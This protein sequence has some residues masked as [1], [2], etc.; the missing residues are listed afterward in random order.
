MCGFAGILGLSGALI[1]AAPLRAMTEVQR[2]RG[3]D[4]QAFAWV[5]AD[6]RIV[7]SEAAPEA[8]QPFPCRFA[9]GFNRLSIR[10]LSAAGRQ[11]MTNASGTVV[12][13]F[14]G[15]IYNADEHRRRLA[16]KGV[17][18]RGS[19]DTEVILALY[20]ERGLDGMLASL[21]GM[22]ALVLVDVARG[23][24]YLIRDRLGIKPLYYV[25]RGEALLVASE[26]KA[27]LSVPGFVPQADIEGLHETLLFRFVS[28]ERQL[29]SG[30]R[31]VPPGSVLQIS[32]SGVCMSE[33]WR[34]PVEMSPGPW[35]RGEVLEAVEQRLRASV[36]AQLISDVPVGCQLSGGVDSS[37]ISVLS[38]EHYGPRLEGFSIVPDDRELSEDAWIDAASRTVGLTTH[39]FPLDAEA[40]WDRLERAAWHMDE[41]IAHP[42]SVG[43]L[44]LA[45][46]AKSRMTVFMSGEGADELFGG[47]VRHFFAALRPGWRPLL[48]AAGQ[49]VFRKDFFRRR[50]LCAEGRSEAEWYL[51]T[52][53]VQTEQD[54]R[55]LWP[56]FSL[57]KALHG[58]A[59]QLQA[60]QGADH[61]QRL[62]NHDLRTYLVSLLMRQDKM[63]MAHSIENRVPFLDHEL[64]E[65]VRRL[66]GSM[67]VPPKLALAN[68][69]HT[70]RRQSKSILKEIAARY[71]TEDF[72]YRKKGGFGLPIAA[73]LRHPR[74]VLFMNER[75]LPGLRQ[76]GLFEYGAVQGMWKRVLAGS[77]DI[78][79][80]WMILAIELWM[81]LFLD[82]KAEPGATT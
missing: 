74:G 40:F 63:T 48:E 3:P 35:Q 42:N 58:P 21:N 73:Y 59:E 32:Q 78:E 4:D 2:H 77:N 54:A 52:T 49:T 53:A 66:P 13:V 33:Y 19:S 71:F 62:L 29:L 47:Y 79:R 45:E 20:E 44:R 76:R 65:L 26:I 80:L 39:K 34:P 82:R 75:I 64:V 50:L 81:Q 23:R 7:L 37:L 6:G 36:E 12:C 31:A 8:G 1:D 38:K 15:E 24:T 27:F 43:I 5:R 16:G 60:M 14:N 11:P 56:D 30:V 67:L 70:I 68:P 9:L 61:L 46:G 18:F 69:R 10:D 51:L 28:G 25:E 55:E 17:R 72:V 41:P 22:F 57:H